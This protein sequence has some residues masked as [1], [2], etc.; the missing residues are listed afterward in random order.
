MRAKVAELGLSDTGVVDKLVALYAKKVRETQ[1]HL[2][3]FELGGCVMAIV[4][5]EHDELSCEM[6]ASVES[7]I[8]FLV[9]MPIDEMLIQDR[10]EN[11]PSA[12]ERAFAG[13]SC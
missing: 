2:T 13:G 3:R 11:G 6:F 7:L 1:A 9:G 10:A 4:G 12:M 8:V 5:D